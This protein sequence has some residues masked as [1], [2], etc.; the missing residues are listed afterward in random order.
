MPLKT[1]G[2]M[3]PGDMGS[4]IGQRLRLNGLDVITCLEG[5]S[6]LSRLRAKEAGIRDVPT[7][8]ALVRE[9]DLFLSIVPPG[10]A[11]AL[12]RHVAEATERTGATPVYADFNAISPDTTRKVGDIVTQAGAVFVDGGI[13]GGAPGGKQGE[14]PRLYWSGPDTTAMQD[15]GRYGLDVRRV[16]KHIGQASGLK[17]LYAASTKGTI[18]LW[19]ELLTA[20]RALDLTRDL[21]EEL[22]D[23]PVYKAMQQSIPGMP[24]RS[25]RWVA[26]MREIAETFGSLGL[27]PTMML[28]AADMYEMVG[29]T[30]LADRSERD[31]QPTLEETLAA[32]MRVLER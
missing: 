22:Q 32:L 12:A 21:E 2:L 4:G 29:K 19:T 11:V 31:P 20:A 6:A 9:A 1:V 5:R 7:L 15:L 10:E 18:A 25:R 30:P 28:G 17:M 23:S 27:T 16:G 24:R 3:S 26:E 14:G 8:D 13:I